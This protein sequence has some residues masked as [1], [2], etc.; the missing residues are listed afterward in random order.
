MG[1]KQKQKEIHEKLRKWS[2][3]K[4]DAEL[5]DILNEYLATLEG[6]DTGS[7]PPGTHPSKPPGTPP[8]RG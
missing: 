1:Q 4:G 7:N 8:G 6:D 2:N 5:N 3:E